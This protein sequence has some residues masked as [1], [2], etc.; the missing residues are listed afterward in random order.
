M[1][2][3][4]KGRV[5]V[6]GVPNFDNWADSFSEGLVRT[7]IKNKYGFA[8]RDG[9]IVIAPAYDWASPF[10]HGSA[11]ACN[12][13]HEECAN[14]GGVAPHQPGCDH[15]IMTGGKW[16]KI[17]KKGRIVAKLAHVPFPD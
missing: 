10:A 9:K 11:N 15:R 2:V 13:C 17:N 3:N 1:Y 12:E 8:N 16:F 4:R 5:V 6:S 7:V 14:P